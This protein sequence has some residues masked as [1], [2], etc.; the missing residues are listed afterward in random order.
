MPV[1]IELRHPPVGSIRWKSS[2]L[3][4]KLLG[5]KLESTDTS[6]KGMNCGSF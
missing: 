5:L 2:W 1:A 3:W 4:E 6:L